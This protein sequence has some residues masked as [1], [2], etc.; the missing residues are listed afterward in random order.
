MSTWQEQNS[1]Y[2]AALS[3]PI[4]GPA[5]TPDLQF[6]APSITE[7]FLKQDIHGKK[8][9]RRLGI[10]IKTS[11]TGSQIADIDLDACR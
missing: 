4:F 2:N 10:L 7:L 11:Q 6:P 8:G 3:F 9:M 1:V 5:V